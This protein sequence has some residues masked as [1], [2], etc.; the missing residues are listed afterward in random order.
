MLKIDLGVATTSHPARRRED[1][2]DLI[3]GIW[4]IVIGNKGII[5]YSGMTAMP[6]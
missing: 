1:E 5:C 4:R 3:D 6:A 2:L